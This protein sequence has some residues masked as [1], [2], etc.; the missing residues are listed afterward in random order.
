MALNLGIV[1]M[2]S[3]QLAHV[4][5]H[6]TKKNLV[7]DQA[8]TWFKAHKVS[9]EVKGIGAVMGEQGGNSR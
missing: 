6:L 8:S 1:S 5:N 3:F 7:S 4:P 2:G 9:I